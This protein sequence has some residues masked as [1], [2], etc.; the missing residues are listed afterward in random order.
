MA[1][2]LKKS[3]VAA[4]CAAS[5]AGVQAETPTEYEVKAAFV[6]NIAKFV[7]WPVV[8]PSPGHARMCLLGVDSSRGAFDVLQGKPAG[9]LYW[10]V[11]HVNGGGSLKEC[12]VLFIA[13]SESANLG[14]ILARI[15]G[16]PILTV[17]DTEG[18]AG[19]GVMVNFYP[20]ESRVRFEINR[21]AAARA[22]LK[23]DARLLGLAR[24]VAG[25]DQ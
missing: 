13:A 24:I 15:K 9:E 19:Q 17:G 12:R 4:L 21:Q 2:A 3:L 1:G 16:S 22:G 14:H 5:C 10:E 11:V 25:G 18:Y 23:M 6:Y 7:E 20:E 8:S